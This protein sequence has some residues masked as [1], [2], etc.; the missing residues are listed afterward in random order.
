MLF[1][2]SQDSR[3]VAAVGVVE[4]TLRTSDPVA[5]MGFV[6]R[7][8]VYRPD[9]IVDMCRSVATVLAILFRQD[10]FVDPVWSLSELQANGVLS[11]WPQS[12]T[13][14]RGRGAAWVHSRLTE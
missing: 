8:T 12:I 10:R 3:A 4:E 6:G 11:G 13:Q 2:R 5:V 14:V 1:Y 7:R 9:E